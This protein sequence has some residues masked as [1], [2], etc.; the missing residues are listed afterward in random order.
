[1]HKK[2]TMCMAWAVFSLPRRHRRRVGSIDNSTL[3]PIRRKYAMAQ[4]AQKPSFT[5]QDYLVWE[6][7]QTQRH[8]FINGEVFAMA[9]AEDR[10]VTVTM[11]VAFLLREHLRGG[12]CR[13][14]MS[15]MRLQVN[16]RNSYF[17]PDVLV[18][19]SAQDAASPQFKAEP[20]LIVEVLSTGTAA[21]DRGIKFSHYRQ[22]PT[23]REYALID[24][25]ERSVDVYRLGS[26]GFWVLHPYAQGET[27]FFSS[28][29]LAIPSALIFAD[30]AVE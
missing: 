17:Y 20:S 14:Y 30:I 10:H 13:T 28:A 4:V 27:V 24:I 6:A 29:D 12:P 1:M 21:Y 19:C 11:N 5:G 2:H 8:E 25:N 16:A 26:E 9:G 3:K 22:I 23:L 15:D 7:N 18:T